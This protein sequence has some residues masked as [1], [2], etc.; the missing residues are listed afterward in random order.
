MATMSFNPY[1]QTFSQEKREDEDEQEET[2]K[3]KMEKMSAIEKSKTEIENN[4]SKMSNNEAFLA[5]LS[6]NEGSDDD[7]WR[8]RD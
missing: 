5:F 8:V 7:E 1:N 3:V 2:L 6:K 4:E